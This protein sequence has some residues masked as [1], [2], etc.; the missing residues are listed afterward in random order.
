MV[1]ATK[2]KKK[3]S[4]K[5]LSNSQ[6]VAIL[7]RMKSGEPPTKISR[8]MNV[9]TS[10][11]RNWRRAAEAAGTWDIGASGDR[12][13]LAR[14][15]PRAKN[16]GSGGHNRKIDDRLL[17]KIKDHLEENP[18]LTPNGLKDEIPELRE[19]HQDTIRR[20][21]TRDLGLP[22]RITATKPFFIKEME[23][24][25]V[26]ED[27]HIELWQ[28]FRHSRRVRRSSSISQ[29][30]PR[31]IRR[32]VKH[33]QKIMVWGCFGNGKLGQLYLVEKNQKMNTEMYHYVLNK[34]LKGSMRN[35]DYQVLR[36]HA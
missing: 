29:Y 2:A 15:A 23:P 16:P 11:M 7:T 4:G 17:Q 9:A 31:F 19:I 35:E 27:P 10:T 28:S 1:R 14:P 21:I 5:Q 13:G 32:S 20:A 12:P 26:V 30:N 24:Q 3:R 18:F 6:K 33:P 22:S 8:Q 25:K 34:H 36:L